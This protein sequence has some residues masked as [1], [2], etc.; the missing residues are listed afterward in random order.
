MSERARNS[1]PRTVAWFSYFPVEWL[2]DAPPEVR[3]L[4][5]MHPASWQRVLLGALEKEHPDLRLHIL[6]L[7]KQFPR[8]SS[9]RIRNVTFHLLRTRGG[10]AVIGRLAGA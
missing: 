1:G 5:R 8:S 2:P 9:F 10:G 7:R 3:A 4:P 6:V